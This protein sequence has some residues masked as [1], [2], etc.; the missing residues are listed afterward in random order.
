MQR[1][2]LTVFYVTKVHIPQTLVLQYVLSVRRENQ[3]R[4]LEPLPVRL[5]T[6]GRTVAALESQAV[7]RAS[8]GT[9]FLGIH[10]VSGARHAR[11]LSMRQLSAPSHRMLYAPL[12]KRV[13]PVSTYHQLALQLQMLHAVHVPLVQQLSTNHLHV[14]DLRMQCVMT[15][16]RALQERR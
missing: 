16:Q 11:E 6:L 13:L 9:P 2:L 1:Q 15:A 4:A 14:L 12:A 8:V 5:A 3:W 10:S 7:M